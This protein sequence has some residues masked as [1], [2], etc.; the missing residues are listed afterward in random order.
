MHQFLPAQA[1]VPK[2]V[3]VPWAEKVEAESEG[4]I[5]IQHF[6]SMQLGGKRLSY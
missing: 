6:P 2:K 5:K 4:R 1:N 3:L